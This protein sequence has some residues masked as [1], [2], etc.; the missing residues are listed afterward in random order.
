MEATLNPKGEGE[1][2]REPDL[3]GGRVA[4]DDDG[5]AS[6]NMG[7][8]FRSTSDREAFYAYSS[9]GPSVERVRSGLALNQTRAHDFYQGRRLDRLDNQVGPYGRRD[10]LPP[11]AGC[12]SAPEAA[13]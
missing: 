6:P 11:R 8:A 7:G 2:N 1:A 5:P 4:E 12:S 9:T 3:G 13:R 10:Q